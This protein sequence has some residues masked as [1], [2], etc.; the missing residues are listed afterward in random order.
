MLSQRE[1][2]EDIQNYAETLEELKFN[3]K[4]HISTLTELA[5][6]Y[7]KNR[8]GREIIEIIKSRIINKVSLNF[9]IVLALDYT[10]CLLGYFGK[11]FFCVK[12]RHQ[13][14]EKI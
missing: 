8:Q 6:D 3:S 2:L 9:F 11:N 13:N 14:Q 5:R 12:L 10:V 4:P 7:G 1:K